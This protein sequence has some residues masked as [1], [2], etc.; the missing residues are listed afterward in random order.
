MQGM[1]SETKMAGQ[2]VILTGTTES[3]IMNQINEK[4]LAKDLASATLLMDI[5]RIHE[6]LEIDFPQ[7]T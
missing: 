1:R 3:T 6:V 2:K 7:E 4:R 5:V